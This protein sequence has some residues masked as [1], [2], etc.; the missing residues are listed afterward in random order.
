MNRTQVMEGREVE[1]I[2]YFND[3]KIPQ[4]FWD[5]AMNPVVILP[6]KKRKYF[7]KIIPEKGKKTVIAIPKRF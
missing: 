4:L 6:G 3:T 2:E 7:S 1:E 5:Y